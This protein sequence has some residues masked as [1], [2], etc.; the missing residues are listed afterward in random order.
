MLPIYLIFDVTFKCNSKCITCFNWSMLNRKDEDE[1]LLDEIKK[2]S[3]QLD[4][5]LW[6]LLSGG[7][8]FLRKDIDEICEI[9]YIQNNVKRITIPTN[10]LM[11]EVIKQKTESILQKCTKANV[12]IS[13]SLDDIG[14]RHDAI[15]GVKGNFEKTLE[16]YKILVELKKKYPKLSININTV[17]FH[18]NISNIDKILNFVKTNLKDAD[19]HGFEML[20]SQPRGMARPIAPG[21]YDKVLPKLKRYWSSYD[22]YN[23]PFSKV[24]KGLKIM[25]RDIELETIKTGKNIDCYAGSISGVIGAQGDVQ[26]CELL[27]SVGNLKDSNFNFKKIWFSETAD[28]QRDMIKDKC[29]LCSNCTHSCFVSSSI[30]FN[31]KMYP[32]L[33]KYIIKYAF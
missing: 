27:P 2:I 5:I 16:T 21:I 24:M 6:L 10:G 26:L 29:E 13:L 33:I 17:L 28:M 22:F 32:K 14:E 1:L 3:L 23:M 11:P 8:P 20:R 18:K 25:A 19:F 7:E 9:F 31:Y 15:R 12:V 4:H 30:V